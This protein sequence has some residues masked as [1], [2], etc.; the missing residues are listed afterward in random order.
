MLNN[1]RFGVDILL[2]S[3]N[4]EDLQQIIILYFASKMKGLNM[5]LN[6]TKVM[7]NTEDGRMLTVRSTMTEAAGEYIYLGKS[8]KPNQEN[9]RT[10]INRRI[11]MEWAAFR[12]LSYVLNYKG[13]LINR[14]SRVFNTCILPV[15]TYTA[16]I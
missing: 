6:K 11:L 12:R 7:A 4:Y 15:L 5:N 3:D 8:I 10:E 2:T 9:Q 14:R 1:L 16:Q 13:T